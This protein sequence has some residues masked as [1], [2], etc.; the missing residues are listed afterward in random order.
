MLAS[1][2]GLAVNIILNLLLMKTLG[3]AGIALATTLATATSTVFML[4][5]FNRLGHI[6]WIDLTMIALSWMLFTTLVICLHYQSYPGVIVSLIA[7][8][9][10]LYSE[11]N[12]LARWRAET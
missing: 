12:I 1:L 4:L 7:L 9:V 2:L 11:W 5:L 3:A 10:F 8:S 6:S